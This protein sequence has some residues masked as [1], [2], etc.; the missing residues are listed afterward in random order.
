MRAIA[1]FHLVRLWGPLP[2]LDKVTID[3]SN[4]LQRNTVESIY[5]FIRED[6]EMAAD[7]LPLER[8]DKRRVGKTAAWSYLAKLHLTLNEYSEALKYSDE[9]INSG[10][11]A[12]EEEYQDASECKDI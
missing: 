7:L 5:R 10:I 1:Y 8:S 9:V 11:H 6:L 3:T 12:L 2:I 4:P